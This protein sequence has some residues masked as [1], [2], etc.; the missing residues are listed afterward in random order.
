MVRVSTTARYAKRNRYNRH[1]RS[2]E[3]AM[4][5]SRLRRALAMILAVDAVV[6]IAIVVAFALQALR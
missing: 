6:L 5:Q 4:M 1:T 3:L 2:V